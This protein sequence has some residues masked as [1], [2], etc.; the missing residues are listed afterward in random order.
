MSTAYRVRFYRELMD[1][2]GNPVPCMLGE[3]SV[4]ARDQELARRIACVRFA[5]ERR[6]RRWDFLATGVAV[7]AIESDG[8]PATAQ[9]AKSRLRR[10]FGENASRA[11]ERLA[12]RARRCERYPDAARWLAVARELKAAPAAA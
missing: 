4:V 3:T 8:G 5:K 11:A 10:Q 1:H 2:R 6:V 7:D 12:L 9:R